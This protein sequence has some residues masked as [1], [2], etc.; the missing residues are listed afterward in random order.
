MMNHR[1]PCISISALQIIANL[2]LI[3]CILL[4]MKDELMIDSLTV[5]RGS[6][7]HQLK[8]LL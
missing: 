1:I 4:N 2:S 7:K 6:V 8:Y 5:P 3:S